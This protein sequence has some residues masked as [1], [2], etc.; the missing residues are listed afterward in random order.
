MQ[1]GENTEE[2]SY[3]E[4]LEE[5]SHIY[6]EIGALEE[7]IA[8]LKKYK[9]CQTCRTKIDRDMLFCPRCGAKVSTDSE[10]SEQ[11]SSDKDELILSNAGSDNQDNSDT[12]DIHDT[13]ENENGNENETDLKNYNEN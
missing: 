5:I 11:E 6:S 3:T 4:L 8:L 12:A 7:Q 9:I 13:N 2:L 10:S 1:N